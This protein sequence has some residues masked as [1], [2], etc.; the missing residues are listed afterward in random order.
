MDRS[1]AEILA[2]KALSWAAAQD[3]TLQRFAFQTGIEIDEL[4]RLAGDPEFLAGFLDFILSDDALMKSFCDEAIIE[5]RLLHLA[6]H[7][8]PGSGL[9]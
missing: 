3:G 8:L 4:R 7:V 2:L 9:E 6:R 5:T 1:E